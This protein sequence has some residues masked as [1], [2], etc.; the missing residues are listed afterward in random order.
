M[1][2]TTRMT[3]SPPNTDS[4]NPAQTKRIVATTFLLASAVLA[5]W[6]FPR[7]WYTR[8]DPSQGY[9]WLA[10][11]DRLPGWQFKSEQVSKAAEGVL[12]ADKVV[13][14]GFQNRRDQIVRVFSAKRYS[15]GESEHD[16]F[17]HTPDQCWT[18]IGWKLE[19]GLPDSI[20]VLVDG[21]QLNL[22]RRIFSKDSHRELVYF[23]A[24]VGG[25][26]L[27]YRLD[28]YLNVALKRTHQ[29]SFGILA[30]STISLDRRLFAWPLKSFV[31]RRPL[32]GPKQF[33]RVSTPIIGDD[34]KSADELLTDFLS[35]WL[36]SVDYLLELTQ[37]RS[38]QRSAGKSII[39]P[40]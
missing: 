1:A 5:L 3:A 13:N 27:P 24:L 17:T 12:G 18:A 20:Q 2:T 8:T 29:E 37:W 25:Q 23:G 32:V 31:S 35:R 21:L 16:M 28:H 36:T 4:S 7:F 11:Q 40:G 14:G 10:E 19:P 38:R 6:L 30:E 15:S 33:I 9:F 22:E 39:D 34:T 26:P